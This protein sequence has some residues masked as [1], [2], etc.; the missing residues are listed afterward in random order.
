MRSVKCKNFKLHKS[1]HNDSKTKSKNK[2]Q[3]SKHEIQGIN[4]KT[5]IANVQ[6]AFG[7]R[8]WAMASVAIEV[9]LF[10]S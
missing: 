7:N 3:R 4:F 1:E 2:A 8:K 5:F 9:A 10:C 6:S